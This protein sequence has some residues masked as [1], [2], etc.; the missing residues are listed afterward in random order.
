MKIPTPLLRTAYR[1]AYMLLRVYWFI[2]RPRV[3]GALALLVHA[4]QLL[5]VR[6]TY[7]RRVWTLPGGMIKRNEDPAAA[8]R[9]EVHEEVG[10]AVEGLQLV[11]VFTGRQA[12]RHDTIHIFTAPVSHP[13]VHI[14]PG[15]IL[16]A[17]WFPLADLPRL[18]T[19]TRRAIALWQS[20]ECRLHRHEETLFGGSD[21]AP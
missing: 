12:Q 2:M 17:Q 20:Q 8:M 19:Y 18:S 15:E 14:D 11:G 6:N 21:R 7:G 3:R 4:D 10:I 9:R 13:V 16:D 1:C 5:L